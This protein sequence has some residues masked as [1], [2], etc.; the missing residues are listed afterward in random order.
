MNEI[1]IETSVLKDILERKKTIEGRLGT[2]RFLA[3]KP[4]DKISLRED[5][6]QDGQ[7]VRSISGRAQIVVKQTVLF[8]TFQEMLSSLD[9]V[10]IIPNAETL[11]EAL[12][13]Y[14]KFYSSEDEKKY[15]V[16]AIEFTLL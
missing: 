10:T 6:W 7:I 8:K 11:E 14:R 4:G 3:F 2:K 1:G 5:I 13:V 16:V 9:F 15:G 12:V